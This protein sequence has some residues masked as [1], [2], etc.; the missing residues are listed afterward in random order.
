MTPND[1][2]NT[3]TRCLSVHRKPDGKTVCTGGGLA[4][5]VEV[6]EMLNAFLQDCAIDR[7]GA[8]LSWRSFWAA[9][10]AWCYERRMLPLPAPE[11]I[12]EA[13][14]QRFEPVDNPNGLAWG[15]LALKQQQWLG[16]KAEQLEKK[17]QTT[18][19]APKADEPQQLVFEA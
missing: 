1:G 19:R 9:F 7:P 13:V 2:E 12:Q 3:S 18:K 16:D 4:S 15:G 8:L 5:T 17:S 11:V 10:R 6:P 14:S